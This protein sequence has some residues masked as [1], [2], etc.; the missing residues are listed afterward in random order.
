MCFIFIQFKAVSTF[1]LHCCVVV[2][3]NCLDVKCLYAFSIRQNP[4]S[5][6][7]CLAR[8]ILFFPLLTISYE[9]QVELCAFPFSLLHFK[10]STTR[11]FYVATLTTYKFDYCPFFQILFCVNI[12]NQLIGNT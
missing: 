3:Q 5:L 6:F 9:L 2:V 1:V 11:Y 8:N 4:F 10:H 12:L 7:Y